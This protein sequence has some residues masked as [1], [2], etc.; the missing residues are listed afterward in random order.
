MSV[1]DDGI[2]VAVPEPNRHVD[3][4]EAKAPVT[5]KQRQVKG[6][7]SQTRSQRPHQIVDQHGFDIGILERVAIGFGPKARVDVKHF[8]GNRDKR[9]NTVRERASQ[10]GAM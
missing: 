10:N 9:A 1:R 2:G 7:G 6:W 4:A 8:G 3:V 5:A